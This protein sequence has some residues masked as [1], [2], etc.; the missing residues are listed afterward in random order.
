M[1]SLTV[2][3]LTGFNF[4]RLERTM[5]SQG[6]VQVTVPTAGKELGPG[7][8]LLL[9]SAGRATT[10]ASRSVQALNLPGV[11]TELVVSMAAGT[12]PDSWRP[13]VLGP[14]PDGLF[15]WRG[16]TL[17]IYCLPFWWFAGLGLDALFSRYRLHWSVL[18]LGTLLCGFFLFLV[19]GLAIAWDKRDDRDMA[20]VFCGFAIWVPLLAA[21]PSTWIRRLRRQ[22]ASKRE[23]RVAHP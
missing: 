11:A 22:R 14:T 2:E 15:V 18:L 4:L 12:W 19:T 9:A 10:F 3:A 21:F 20:F 7:P 23:D 8:M 6:S 1:C 17:P 16:L 5:A 13:S